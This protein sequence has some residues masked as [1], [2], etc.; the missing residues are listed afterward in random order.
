MTHLRAVPLFGVI[1][2]PLP[3]QA[4]ALPIVTPVRNRHKHD[5]GLRGVLALGPRTCS[6]YAVDGKL[7]G[8]L[9]GLQGALTIW[10]A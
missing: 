5:F 7:C 4:C 10:A 8:L 1:V 3:D 2:L 6:S 9:G